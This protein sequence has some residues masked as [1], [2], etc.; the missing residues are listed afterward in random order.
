MDDRKFMWNN[1]FAS[2]DPMYYLMLK[3]K[4]VEEESKEKTDAEK[5]RH[6][7]RKMPRWD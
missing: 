3:Q 1:F 6:P 7:E 4:R 2:G 5:E